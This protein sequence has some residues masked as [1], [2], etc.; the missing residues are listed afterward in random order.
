MITTSELSRVT[1]PV[2]VY[3]CVCACLGWSP[4]A[5]LNQ[6]D[7]IPLELDNI[8]FH[9]HWWRPLPA[10]TSYWTWWQSTDNS[11][12]TDNPNGHHKAK[13]WPLET[14]VC[15]YRRAP[16]IV[17][18]EPAPTIKPLVSTQNRL[19]RPTDCTS[20]RSWWW[21][22]KGTSIK[23]RSLIYNHKWLMSDIIVF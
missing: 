6:C 20:S 12:I 9:A 5:S 11:P 3:V 23:Y 2:D 14:T 8:S 19:S 21:I 16:M 13:E 1:K 15:A 4:V 17:R 7:W 18:L 10:L 22:N